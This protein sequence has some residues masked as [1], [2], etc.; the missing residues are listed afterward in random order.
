MKPYIAIV[1]DDPDDQKLIA[2]AFRDV[3]F[4]HEIQFFSTG[5]EFMDKMNE[6][7]KDLGLPY[8][9]IMDQNMPGKEGSEIIHELKKRLVFKHIPVVILTGSMQAKYAKDVY[10]F[11]ASCVLLK[12]DNFDELRRIAKSIS[13]LWQPIP[14]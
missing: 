1:D 4:G 7:D 6:V 11:G 13:F 14:E 9:I 8:L 10:F 5:E 12:P 3:G 2:D